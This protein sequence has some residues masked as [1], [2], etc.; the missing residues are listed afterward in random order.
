MKKV[1]SLF[2][3]SVLCILSF[4]S[5]SG[6]S[7]VKV[8]GVKID[9]EVY[10]YFKDLHKGNEAQINKALSRYVAINTEFTSHNLSLSPAQKS[11]LSNRVND[12]WHLYSTHYLELEISKQT[13]YKIE[14]SKMYEDVLLEYYYGTNGVYPVNEDEIKKYFKEHYIAIHFATEYLFNIDEN[15]ATVP[16]SDAERSAIIGSFNRSADLIS[17][18]TTIEMATTRETHDTIINSFYDGTF[19]SGFYREVAKLEVN[20]A[21]TVILGDYVFLVQR[22]DV[23]D[24]TYN[25]YETYRTQC[26]RDLK[27]ADFNAMVEKWSQNYKVD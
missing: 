19:P 17:T 20:G 18:G 22:I 8:N 24:K 6:I 21:T 9:N 26:L 16:M 7:K 13:I 14:T 25:Y 1:L 12:L 3:V 11:E 4:S 10:Y 2:L 27:G 23:F 15:G 5:C